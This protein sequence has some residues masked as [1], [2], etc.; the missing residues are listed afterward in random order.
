MRDSHVETFVIGD[1][2]YF[3]GYEVDNPPLSH[4]VGV[5]VGALGDDPM[6]QAYQ[7]LWFKSNVVEGV[8]AKHLE[9]AYTKNV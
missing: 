9:L 8:S 5:V 4:R 3:T 7:V 2:V 6:F 1:L